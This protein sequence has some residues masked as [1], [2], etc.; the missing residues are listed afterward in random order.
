MLSGTRWGLRVLVRAAGIAQVAVFVLISF[1]VASRASLLRV[2]V[3]A[4]K[5]ITSFVAGRAAEASMVASAAGMS[6]CASAAK[7]PR[8]PLLDGNAAA[9][10]A[11]GSSGP[12]LLGDRPA[13]H[14]REA[15]FEA[16]RRFGL[17]G[18]QR[19]QHGEDVA[20]ADLGDGFGAEA[21]QHVGGH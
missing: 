2:A 6:L 8:W 9:T 19:R 10:A 12:V 17:G 3:S 20:G 14:R 11:V 15:P 18:P 21:G 16:P 1:Q 13:Q 4:R 7:W 5:R